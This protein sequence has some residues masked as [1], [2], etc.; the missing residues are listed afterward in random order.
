[1]SVE[2]KCGF[3]SV[4]GR[5]NVGK[6]TLVNAMVGAKVSI[7]SEKVQTTRRRV[8]GIAMYEGED[9][10][11]QIILVDTPGIFAAK[12]SLEKSMVNAAYDALEEGEVIALLVDAS[13]KNALE[14]NKDLMA[15]LPVGKKSFLILNKTDQVNK[16]DLLRVSAAF[17]AAFDF[18]QTFMISALKKSGVS[19][20][21]KA[22]AQEVREGPFLFDPEQITDMSLRF[23]A[24]EITREKIYDFLYRELPYA[25][26]IETEAWEEFDNGDVKISQIIYVQ[27]DSQKA[28]VLGKGGKGVKRIGEASRAEL[29]EFLERRV[30]LKLFVKVQEDWQERAEILTNMGLDKV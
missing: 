4:I 22:L 10:H 19:D 6:S 15:K 16:P 14:E 28:I 18:D 9:M 24:A 23:M 26:H 13:K 27:K 1:M 11:A 17:N 30:H 3:I 2:N 8:L 12:K 20:V 7:T 5:P 25:I 21:M 29:E